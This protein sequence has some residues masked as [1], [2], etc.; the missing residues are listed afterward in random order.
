MDNKLK[1]IW[2]FN[3][4]L[5]QESKFELLSNIANA[6]SGEKSQNCGTFDTNFQPNKCLMTCRQNLAL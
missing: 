5:I 1:N 3:I 2:I 4:F 6:A